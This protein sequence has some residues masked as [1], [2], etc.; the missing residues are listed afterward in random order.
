MLL[1]TLKAAANSVYGCRRK[2]VRFLLN[3]VCASCGMSLM[4][5][6]EKNISYSGKT[7]E[8]TAFHAAC[9]MAV[10]HSGLRDLLDL[11]RR[12]YESQR[13]IKR[14]E[15]LAGQTRICIQTASFT[16]D[17]PVCTTKCCQ[18]SIF[19][20]KVMGKWVP[21]LGRGPQHSGTRRR[22]FN[23]IPAKSG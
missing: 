10:R 16:V 21:G 22:R 1:S 12:L 20:L 7:P 13:Y 5:L 6:L 8:A 17:G 2:Y 14:G 15:D 3:W 9:S 19:S 23:L 11:R 18:W 4:P